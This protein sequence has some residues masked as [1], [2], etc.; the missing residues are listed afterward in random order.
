MEVMADNKTFVAT[1]DSN[2]RIELDPLTLDT[3]KEFKWLGDRNYSGGI[4]H[5]RK[6]PDGTIIS[7]C[8]AM[9]NNTYK[10]DLIVYKLDGENTRKK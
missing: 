8:T 1:N 2:I 9:N 4:S 7:I 10:M 3:K 6:L 5:S